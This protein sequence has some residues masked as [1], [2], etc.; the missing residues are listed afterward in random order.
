M[1]FH[2]Y[3]FVFTGFIELRLSSG[4][5]EDN[6]DCKIIRH[7]HVTVEGWGEVKWR[8]LTCNNYL[9]LSDYADFI[10]L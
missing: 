2:L 4:A 8:A 5:A 7:L 6:N 1:P 9:V 3:V 10:S